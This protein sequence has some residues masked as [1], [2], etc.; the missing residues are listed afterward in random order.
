MPFSDPM[1]DGLAVQASSLRALKAG[2]KL[3]KTLALVR[4]FRKDDGDTTIVLMGYYNPFS[5]YG[6]ETFGADSQVAGRDALIIVDVPPEEDAATFLH[7]LQ[8]DVPR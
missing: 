3:A 2:M 4:A 5:T 1:A 7:A 8:E 6:V